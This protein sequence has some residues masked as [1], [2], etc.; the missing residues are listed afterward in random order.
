MKS[1]LRYYALVEVGKILQ[2]PKPRGNLPAVWGEIRQLVDSIKK[3]EIRKYSQ[4]TL[5]YAP[6][7]F[8]SL[9]FTLF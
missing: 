7:Y 2:P 9:V 1:V 6:V 8:I 3:Q 5:T 4:S